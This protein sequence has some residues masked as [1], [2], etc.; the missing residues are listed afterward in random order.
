M[1]PQTCLFGPGLRLES[2]CEISNVPWN[3]WRSLNF[4][5]LFPDQIE[6]EKEST[7]WLKMLEDNF[8]LP[9][10]YLNESSPFDSLSFIFPI[11][12]NQLWK[13]QK[14]FSSL[15][16][17][18]FCWS[19]QFNVPIHP[20]SC[21]TLNVLL[22]GKSRV[23]WKSVDFSCYDIAWPFGSLNSESL[24]CSRKNFDNIGV[25]N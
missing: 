18:F 12:A 3:L 15:S 21:K 6:E 16:P 10:R 7:V 20:T 1:H 22:T 4:F 13:P 11:Y 14:D 5:L 2:S 25:L 17:R 9:G 19:V 8:R 23:T 24:R